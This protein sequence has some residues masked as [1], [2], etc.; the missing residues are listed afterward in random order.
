MALAVNSYL[1]AQI[2]RERRQ[3][4]FV[5]FT[6]VC[7]KMLRDLFCAAE[8][9][10]LGVTVRGRFLQPLQGETVARRMISMR[11]GDGRSKRL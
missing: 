9:D 8:L 7:G 6:K 11:E 3:I 4:L 1:A 10:P 2:I 5:K